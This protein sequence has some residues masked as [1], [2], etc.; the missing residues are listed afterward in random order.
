MK[1]L[2]TIMALLIVCCGAGVA[3]YECGTKSVQGTEMKF[4]T[5]SP[6]QTYWVTLK[7]QAGPPDTYMTQLD[8][9]EHTVKADASKSGKMIF[10]NLSIYSGDGYDEGF[11]ALYPDYRWLSDSVL[12]FGQNKNFSQPQQAEVYI[13]NQTQKTIPYLYVSAGKYYI[14]LLFDLPPGSTTKLLLNLQF[15][16]RV[17]G[18]EGKFDDNTNIPFRNVSFSSKDETS[19]DAHYCI[20]ISDS[21][22]RIESREFEGKKLDGS[23]VPKAA[24]AVQTRTER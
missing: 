1:K 5:R 14:F 17:I 21:D 8:L 6:Q 13:L 23:L 24:C 4:S 22:I 9:T 19:A 18:C 3:I 11:K 2:T 12:E 20:S 15:W 16:E 10:E 7:G